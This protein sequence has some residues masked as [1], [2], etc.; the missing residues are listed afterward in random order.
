VIPHIFQTVSQKRNPVIL[1]A[2]DFALSPG[3][4]RS[5]VELVGAGRLSATGC[6]SV[7]RFWPEHAGWLRDHADDADIGL[8]LTLTD[9]KPL[10]AMQNLAPSGRLPSN[11]RLIM[12][13]LTGQLRKPALRDE[14]R[15]EIERQIDAFEDAFDRPPAFIDGHHHA[16][17]LP[18]IG[19]LVLD[20]FERRIRPHG[21]YVR[22]CREPRAAILRRAAPLRALVIDAL[23]ADFAE[24]VRARDNPAN[25]SFR[26]VRNFSARERFDAMVPRFL[27]GVGE[28]PLVMCHP[29]HVDDAL[30]ALDPV[31]D[32][33]AAEHAYLS[34]DL[35][36][37]A[38]EQAGMRLSRF[39]EARGA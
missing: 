6:M 3:V 38:L 29:G 30:C 18:H 8:H 22:V 16:H 12:A 4:S 21:G 10:G 28:I 39:G 34:G 14:L 35:F 11:A 5:I 20:A 36:P 7:S 24:R 17:Q 1:C 13:S 15:D 19:T 32:Q 2:D 31:T 27:E 33:R 26:G 25:D 23:G 37:Q 9:Q